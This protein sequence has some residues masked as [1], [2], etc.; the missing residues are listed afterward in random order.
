MP[1]PQPEL[2]VRQLNMYV[3]SLIEGDVNLSSVRLVGEISNL[4]RHF[5]RTLVFCA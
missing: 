3:R 1:M 4:K 5:K 2:T